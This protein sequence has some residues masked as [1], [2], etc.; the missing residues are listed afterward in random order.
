MS[1]TKQ[2]THGLAA[3]LEAM[4]GPFTVSDVVHVKAGTLHHPDT[5]VEI[6]GHRECGH[7][8]YL[9]TTDNEFSAL[10]E[11]ETTE[12]AVEYTR[13]VSKGVGFGR[14]QVIRPLSDVNWQGLGDSHHNCP[15]LLRVSL[16][17]PTPVTQEDGFEDRLTGILGYALK[18]VFHGQM[19]AGAWVTAA[20]AG[21]SE[22][23]SDVTLYANLRPE[24]NN[25]DTPDIHLALAAFSLYLVKGTPRRT[26]DRSGPNTA[27]TCLVEGFPNL[28]G[29]TPSF[30]W[31]G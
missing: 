22:A 16:C 18:E 17:C 4:F 2:E 15:P 24:N 9:I 29:I 3:G 12:K 5:G 30:G 13:Y 7:Y 21:V 31:A 6:V 20:K 26:T 14:V 11:F 23:Y 28:K 27:G 25:S 19:I 1:N 8:Y 10:A